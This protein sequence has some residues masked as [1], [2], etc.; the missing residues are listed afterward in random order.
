MKKLHVGIGDRIEMSTENATGPVTAT[1]VGQVVLPPV[2]TPCNPT[3]RIDTLRS[4]FAAF[5]IKTGGDIVAADSV[6]ARLAPGKSVSSA[7][8]DMVTRS[9]EVTA[10]AVRV[11]AEPRILWTSGVDRFPLLLGGGA[12]AA[13]AA[14]LVQVLVSSVRGGYDLATLRA[15]PQPFRLAGVVGCSLRSSLLAIVI[16]P[17][18]HPGRPTRVDGVRRPLRVHRRREDT[19]ARARRM[20]PRLLV[21]K[22]A[23]R[24]PHVSRRALGPRSSRSN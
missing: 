11:R 19:G 24:F 17:A 22:H 13:C 3:T 16:G 23:P 9:S 21:A 20:R 15:R 18:R 2:L 10:G 14:T 6:Y 5:G 8:A 1:V 4:T 7:L 12:R